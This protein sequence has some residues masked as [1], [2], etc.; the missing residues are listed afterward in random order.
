MA[1]IKST[2]D[3]ILEKTKN[4]SVTEE[5]KREFKKR[6]MGGKI[7]GLIQK[8]LDGIVDFERLKI[9]AASIG[10]GQENILKQIIIKESV[11][12]ITP[13]QDNEP[14]LKLLEGTAGI[15]ASPVRKVLTD[16][17][18][19]LEKE[20]N[21][22]ERYL[23]NRLKEEGI[24]GSAVLLNPNADPEWLKQVSSMKEGVREKLDMLK[25]KICESC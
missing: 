18:H 1:E 7:K 22:H 23:R 3:I 4:L 15:D 25:R 6:E 2:L 10:K 24:S 9:E 16:F 11:E 12:R 17:E 19:G 5:E 13:G 21:S 14:L 20:R 8:F